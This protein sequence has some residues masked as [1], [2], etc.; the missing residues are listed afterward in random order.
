MSR[1]QDRRLA[2]EI[3]IGL[4]STI[5]GVSGEMVLEWARTVDAGPFSSL[6]VLDR[7]VYPN[8]E[9]L[10]TLAAAAAVTRRVRLA[11][12]VLV[13]PV[14]NATLLAKQAATIDAVSG[15]R[16]TLGLGVGGRQDDFEATQSDFHHRGRRLEEQIALLRR[17]WDG[18]PAVAGTGAIGPRPARPHGPELLIGGYT[19]IAARR[20][21]AL[22]DGFIT[23]GAPPERASEMYALTLDYWQAAGRPGKPRLVGC[24]YFGLGPTARERGT[25]TIRDYYAFLGAGA[26]QMASRLPISEEAVAGGIR[27]FIEAGADELIL[28]PTV[29]S[30][31]QVDRA[32]ELIARLP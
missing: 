10:V 25:A 5:P 13:A 20:A 15:G 31:D 2:M 32:A 12:T 18:E 27:G 7:I 3:G 1:A 16:L 4:P 23:G 28:W 11:T 29:P 8:Y 19:P 21:A 14:R 9:P 22:G 26:E 30:L 6:A 24:M 17:V